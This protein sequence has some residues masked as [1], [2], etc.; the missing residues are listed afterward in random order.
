MKHFN[1][2]SRKLI[3][4]N[5]FLNKF[6]THFGKKFP[7]IR[8]ILRNCGNISGKIW[9]FGDFW[10]NEILGKLWKNYYE[11]FKNIRIFKE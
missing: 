4:G 10:N 3:V 5:I 7:V 11:F 1:E 6:F 8:V 2:I 9:N